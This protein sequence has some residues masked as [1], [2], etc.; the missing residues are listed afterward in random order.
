MAVG[1]KPRLAGLSI[2]EIVWTKAGAL[3]DSRQHAGTNFFTIVERENNIG[4]A[5][6]RQR[7]V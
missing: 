6:S 2:L 5:F 1:S 4:P 7:A 3:R